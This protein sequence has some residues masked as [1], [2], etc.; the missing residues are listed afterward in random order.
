MA[1]PEDTF[2]GFI[3]QDP[4]FNTTPVFGFNSGNLVDK[5]SYSKRTIAYNV[6]R[7]NINNALAQSKHEQ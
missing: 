5:C 7:P 2:D 6:R 4:N 3:P 1:T